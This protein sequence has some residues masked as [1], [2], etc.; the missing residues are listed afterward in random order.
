M[1]F[2][3]EVMLEAQQRGIEANPDYD[4]YNLSIDAGS[5]W[6]RRV[7]QRMINAESGFALAA[8]PRRTC[9]GR[10]TSMG[11]TSHKRWGPARVVDV[12][13]AAQH[14]RRIVL[15]P[16]RPDGPAAPGTHIDIGVYLHGRADVRSYSVVGSSRGGDKTTVGPDVSLLEALEATGADLMY[17]C[18]RGECG[19]CQVKV[20]GVD[21]LIDHRDVFLS[22]EQ[23]G[24]GD[25]L[26]CCVSRVVSPR[27]GGH[28]GVDGRPGVLTIDVP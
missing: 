4:F 26:Q 12:H 17:D 19:L 15:E 7:L 9:S 8:G 18:R 22:A 25:R 23:H 1:F 21:G 11:A 6:T 16:E 3:D 20:L 28:G 13:D 27:T 10:R 14:V 5:M 2:E 24:V